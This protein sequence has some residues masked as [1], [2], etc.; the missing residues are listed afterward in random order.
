MRDYVK[1]KAELYIENFH[2]TELSETDLILFAE[3]LLHEQKTWHYV[4]DKLPQI[5]KKTKMEFPFNH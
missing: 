2:N 5:Q 3:Q 4:T 1:Q